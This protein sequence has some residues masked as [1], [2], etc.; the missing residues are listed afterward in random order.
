MKIGGQDGQFA[1]IG[2][3]AYLVND[4]AHYTNV[5]PRDPAQDGVYYLRI[6]QYLVEGETDGAFI[7]RL[8]PIRPHYIREALDWLCANNIHYSDGKI[9]VCYNKLE[10]W[11]QLNPQFVTFKDDRSLPT[12][13]RENCT[14]KE[15]ELCK[16]TQEDKNIRDDLNLN[17]EVLIEDVG[18]NLDCIKEISDCL[19][20]NID[21]EIIDYLRTNKYVQP[22]EDEYFFEKSFP[23]LFPF[24]VFI[25]IFINFNIQ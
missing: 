6:K 22:Y 21:P 23:H 14:C 12:S 20:P 5:L 13:L 17:K 9:K 10:E 15:T 11:A 8:H 24:G 3:I 16:C 18:E 2:G 7:Y 4:I 19:K 1:T 25:I